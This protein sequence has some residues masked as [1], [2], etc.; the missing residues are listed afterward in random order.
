MEEPDWSRLPL[1]IDYLRRFY[2]EQHEV[3]GYEASPY[4]VAR[5]II[6]RVPLAELAA[7]PLTPGMTLVVPPVP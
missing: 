1:L 4:S 5:P 2:P 7:A 3:I 6:E